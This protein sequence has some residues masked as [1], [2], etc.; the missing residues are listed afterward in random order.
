M[1]SHNGV[2]L[3]QHLCCPPIPPE[4]AQ[5]D[6]KQSV[7]RP[8]I[9]ALCRPFYGRELLPQRDVL[10]DQ[11]LMSSA[12]QHHSAGRQDEQLQ[13]GS[14]VAGA[15]PRINLQRDGWSSGEGH[16]FGRSSAKRS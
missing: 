13:H 9:W 11:F 1:P 5:H 10:Q 16:R 3:Y 4:S 14:I 7:P 15:G 8:K 2:R 6:P 12:R